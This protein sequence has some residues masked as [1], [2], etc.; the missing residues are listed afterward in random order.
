MTSDSN[1]GSL[2]VERTDQNS[3]IAR[4]FVFEKNASKTP[5]LKSP[6]IYVRAF[7]VCRSYGIPNHTHTYILQPNEPVSHY[8]CAQV[9]NS[10]YPIVTTIGMNTTTNS[11]ITVGRASQAAKIATKIEPNR[12]IKLVSQS[13]WSRSFKEI[14]M[15]REP[16]PN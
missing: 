3:K 6:Y 2:K 4:K 5:T 13:C 14:T 12:W 1:V 10:N 11:K 7:R 15:I 8:R 9:A 16:A